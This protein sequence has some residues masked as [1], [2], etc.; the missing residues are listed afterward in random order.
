M[1]KFVFTCGDTNG[2]GPEIVIKAIDKLYGKSK[3][4]FIV[5]IPSNIFEKA[6][7]L[8]KPK[9]PFAVSEKP[10]NAQF[11]DTKVLIISTGKVNHKPG[12]PTKGS[13]KHS[14]LS[15]KKAFELTASKQADAMITAPISKYA[16][17]LAGINFPG[18][19]ELLGEWSGTKNYVMTFLSPKMKCAL[20]TIHEP[21]KNVSRL[22]TRARLKKTIDVVEDMLI[23]DFHIKKPRIAVLGLNPHAGENGKIGREEEDIIK[24]VLSSRTNTFG[25]FVPDAFFANHRAR[26]LRTQLSPAPETP[27]SPG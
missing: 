25:P 7:A 26:S 3:N 16:F 4:K 5:A 10:T 9:F 1:N 20:V 21:V 15:I 23:T 2:I 19:T 22:I 14:F 18:H 12:T 8:V 27:G 17:K 6:S 24:P 13:G 11:N